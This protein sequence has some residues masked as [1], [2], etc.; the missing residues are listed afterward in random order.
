[1]IV[2]ELKILFKK[3]HYELFHIMLNEGFWFLKNLKHLSHTY[4]LYLDKSS[5]FR[6]HKS[7]IMYCDFMEFKKMICYSFVIKP[8]FGCAEATL[9]KKTQIDGF[10]PILRLH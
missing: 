10:L 2:K 9:L 1:M 5:L 8:F 3:L 7:N 6:P 4:S